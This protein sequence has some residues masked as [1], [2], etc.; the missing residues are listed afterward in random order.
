MAMNLA[1]KFS[2]KVDER[3]TRESFSEGV[4]GNAYDFNGVK[5]VTVYSVP[6]APMN[7]YTRHPSDYTNN[8]IQINR[9]GAAIDLQ[10]STQ[11][12][13][14]TKDRSF[15][16]VI[17]RGD[18]NQS[19]M[20]M[21]ANKALSRQINEVIIPEFDT[22]AFNTLA[23]KATA[24]G[25]INTTAATKSN[26]YE[27]FLEGQ[28][29]LG[30]HMAPD[31][32]RIA[33]CSYRFAN[34]LKQDPSFVLASEAGMQI[35]HKGDI[36]MVDG[37][38]VR[39]VPSSRLPNGCSC[40]ITHPYATVGPK[41]L[42]DYK[43][44]DN[45]VGVSGYVVEGRMIYDVFVLNNKANGIWYIGESGVLRTLQ[46]VTSP[47]V[48]SGKSVVTVQPEKDSGHTW[49]Y[50]TG[51]SLTAVAYGDTLTG[52]TAMATSGTEITPTSSH[53]IIQVAELDADSKVV[54][55]GTAVLNIG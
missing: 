4:L 20:V 24:L 55:V 46:V 52:W 19:M 29:F 51:T 50:K 2:D 17:D 15:S 31:D 13:E 18:L 42:Q 45:P 47:S 37:V 26:A 7:D 39:A 54:G 14:L 35:K 5:T 3:F 43:I 41:Q 22:Y 21:E 53:T 16:F 44:H 25:N 28:E 10:A 32:G 33:L 8:P 36:G 9:Y 6:T 23:A 1:A 11:T 12:M 48:T 34:L 38:T 40:I 27:L 49:V 30:D